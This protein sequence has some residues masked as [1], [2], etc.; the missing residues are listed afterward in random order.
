MTPDRQARRLGQAWETLLGKP[1]RQVRY[2]VMEADGTTN[3]F[4]LGA[5]APHLTDDD[6][7]LIHRLWLD[8]T[9]QPGKESAHHR[10]VVSLAL[11][12]LAADLSGPMRDKL[13]AE[14]AADGAT[15]QA[16]RSAVT[17]KRTKRRKGSR[18][19]KHKGETR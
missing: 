12:H 13:L 18:A 14:F 11:G 4:Y 15:K 1:K 6:I 16:D 9:R 5:H 7:N 17:P 2:R 3:D 19:H 8:L 10:D